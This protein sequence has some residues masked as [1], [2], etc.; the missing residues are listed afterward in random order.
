MSISDIT[1]WKAR[2]K[3]DTAR[4]EAALTGP[5]LTFLRPTC[6]A[7]VVLSIVLWVMAIPIRYKELGTVCSRVCGD[8][9]I[10][11][12]TIAQF[13]ASGLTLGFYSAYIGTLEIFF[14]LTFV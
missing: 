10:D 1:A 8:Q 4:T 2:E 9:Q 14:V 13:R 5:W 12:A 6:I 7:V 3:Q 11:R